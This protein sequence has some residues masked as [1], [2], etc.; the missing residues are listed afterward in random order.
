LGPHVARLSHRRKGGE[1][2]WPRIAPEKEELTAEEGEETLAKRLLFL[3]GYLGRDV[4][5]LYSIGKKGEGPELSALSKGSSKRG[6]TTFLRLWEKEK[7]TPQKS[8]S[9]PGDTESAKRRRGFLPK[10]GGIF[11][12]K[13]R[14]GGRQC[15]YPPFC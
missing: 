1:R 12:S 11:P 7:K 8:S 9:S 14:G 4:S 13:R 2:L 10:K 6:G 15:F 5:T 3:R